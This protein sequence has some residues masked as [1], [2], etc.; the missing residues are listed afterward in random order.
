[1]EHIPCTN[2]DNCR[3]RNLGR[4][5]FE[6]VHHEFYPRRMYQT[7]T[8]KRF[9]ELD[10]NKVRICRAEHDEIHAEWTIPEKPDFQVMKAA[11]HAE[12]E[13]RHPEPPE[14]A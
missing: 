7:P 4:G 8:E 1:M 6:D 10:E 13:R 12:Q 5:C 2:Q 11:V 14:A 3:L 9:R